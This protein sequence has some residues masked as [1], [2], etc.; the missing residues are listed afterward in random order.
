MVIQRAK[1]ASIKLKYEAV[2]VVF[3]VNVFGD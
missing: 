1:T 2:L 3:T